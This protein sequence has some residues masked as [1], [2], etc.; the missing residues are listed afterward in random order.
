MELVEGERID[1]FCDARRVTIGQRLRL[2]LQVLAAVQHAHQ[3]LIVHRDLKPSNILVDADGNA[4]LLDFGIATMIDTTGAATVTRDRPLTPEY[5]APEQLE[6]QP[7]T[8]AT[9]VF[10]IGLILAQLLGGQAPSSQRP[11][12]QALPMPLFTAVHGADAAAIAAAR[13]T[14]P[15]ALARML[16]GDLD[17]IV[18]RALAPE[19]ARR[20][21]GAQALAT[22]IEQWLAGR[23]ILA[24][25]DSWLYR[26]RTFVRRHRI[27]V[28][29]SAAA[30]LALIAATAF[31]VQQAR[32]A[33]EAAR[34]AEARALSLRAV[35]DTFGHLMHGENFL[36]DANGPSTAAR[37]LRENLSA[38]DYFLAD[39]PLTR[40]S[41]LWRNGR[42]LRLTGDP[43]VAVKVLRAA[44]DAF[45]K[46]HAAA[47]LEGRA[48][49]LE[50]AQALLESN[51]STAAAATLDALERSLQPEEVNVE[52]HQHTIALLRARIALA[53]GQ[54]DEATRQITSALALAPAPSGEHGARYGTT[55]L[56]AGTISLAQAA[57]AQ[58]GDRFAEA[59]EAMAADPH[60]E[61]APPHQALAPAIETL[62]RLGD[63]ATAQNYAA[64]W[65]DLRKRY[66]GAD[67]AQVRE[68]SALSQRL[69]AIDAPSAADATRAAR[70]RDALGAYWDATFVNYDVTRDQKPLSLDREL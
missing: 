55:A 45:A 58:A 36:A 44:A 70:L 2:M 26:S 53:A 47:T 51:D 34:D 41:L 39:Q 3:R 24:R 15:R 33:R 68:A 23:P 54:L 69:V 50:L 9:D 35:N 20:Y 64:R 62:A 59:L 19:P 38:L 4:K 29:V 25:P 6:G 40:A 60:V 49:T 63:L 21:P 52:L 65:L 46:A 12:A 66:F 14:S 5:A 17:T 13:G 67:S 57:S 18:Q 28:A 1:A 48:A 43:T 37:M 56:L 32:I 31:S 61:L 22:D 30:A 10:A 16:R 7:V 27:G 11:R 42:G 8:T